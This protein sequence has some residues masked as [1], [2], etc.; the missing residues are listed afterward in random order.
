MKTE[1]PVAPAA[2]RNAVG[3]S[4]GLHARARGDLELLERYHRHGDE[5]ARDELV[6]RML[7]VVR[8]LARRYQR[9]SEQLDDLVQ[10]GSLGLVKAIERFDI[11]RGSPFMRYA[12]PTV[13]GEIK[14]HFRDTG[15]AAHVPRGM[16][17]RVM[18]VKRAI[19]DLSSTLGRSPS[20]AEIAERIDMDRE[21]VL[22]AMEAATAYAAVSL[23]APR[24]GDDGERESYAES[25][26]DDDEQYEF[27][28]DLAT[29][30]PALDVLPQRERLIVQL[31]FVDD[32][33]Q[34]EIAERIGVSQ[35][36]VSRLLR[37]ALARVRTVAAAERRPRR[38]A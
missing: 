36:H 32:L 18:E 14:R 6:E 12:V 16:Q 28:E 13:L 30:M 33:T 24:P 11:D 10:V 19:E 35:M 20:P 27:V 31:R 37:R 3:T 2:E 29:V 1:S 7:P 26:G 5:R 34:S 23:D 4:G 38:A 22:D 15:W 8:Q 17:E 21:D 9:G 25:I